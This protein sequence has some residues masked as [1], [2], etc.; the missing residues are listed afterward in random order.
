MLQAMEKKVTA[1]GE[2]EKELFDKFMCYCKSG[3]EALTKSISEAETKIPA[4]TSDIEEA[5]NQVAQ[6]K[7]DL[8]QAQTDRAAAKAAMADAT[9]LRAKEAGEFATEKS[10]A[11]ANIAALGKAT[12]AITKGMAGSFL[13]TSEASVLKNLVLN[14][15]DMADYDR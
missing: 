6:L 5:E 3:G 4:L 9:T 12:A 13:Q 8:K 15:N 11:D 7:A 1:E 14:M 10:E 2:K